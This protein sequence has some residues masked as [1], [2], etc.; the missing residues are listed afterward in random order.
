MLDKFG[1]Y[2]FL[3]LIL[4]ARSSSVLFISLVLTA[5]HSSPGNVKKMFA[6]YFVANVVTARH[7]RSHRVQHPSRGR[8]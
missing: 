6:K 4:Q 3:P 2:C 5:S 7:Q 8:V 1:L